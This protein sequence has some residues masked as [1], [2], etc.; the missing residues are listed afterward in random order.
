MSVSSSIAPMSR[1]EPG[2]GPPAAAKGASRLRGLSVSRRRA[3][4]SLRLHSR[5]L[6]KNTRFLLIA[7][8]IVVAL[9]SLGV[10]VSLRA[11]ESE[12]HEAERNA[13]FLGHMSHVADSIDQYIQYHHNAV[14]GLLRIAPRDPSGRP[15]ISQL[16]TQ[17][18]AV[19]GA[20]V[21]VIYLEQWSIISE[22]GASGIS[23]AALK[24]L[25]ARVARSGKVQIEAAGFGGYLVI[26]AP[27]EGEAAGMLLVAMLS[28]RLREEVVEHGR[29]S[30][31]A[32]ELR[33][34]NGEVLV[35]VASATGTTVALAYQARNT[36]LLRVG[37][38]LS[39]D[40]VA[41]AAALRLEH[42]AWELFAV[43]NIENGL[44]GRQLAAWV[45]LT[46]LMVLLLAPLTLIYWLI[47]VRFYKPIEE[48]K[49]WAFACGE[50]EL[51][52]RLGWSRRET[53]LA[54]LGRVMDQMAAKLDR[55][56]KAR[57]QFFAQVSH[58]IRTPMNAIIGFARLLLQGERVNET[59][60]E[61]LLMI[62]SSGESLLTIINDLLDFAK[63]EVGKL[64]LLP[65]PFRAAALLKSAVTMMESLARGKGLDLRLNLV[66]DLDAVIVADEAR[67]RQV[68][69]NL[70]GNAVKF[71]ERGFVEVRAT[72]TQNA[73]GGGWLTIIVSDTG[74]GLDKGVVD[75]LFSA[76]SQANIEIS[77]RF[78]GTGLG[79]SLCHQLSELMGGQLSVDSV[80]NVGTSF[81]FA[82]PVVYGLEEDLPNEVHET[83]V[84]WQS[85]NV[86]LAEDQFINQ[87]L[88]IAIL[89]RAGHRVTL[90]S[91]GVEAIAHARAAHFDVIL[92]DIQMPEMDGIEAARNIRALAGH[93]ATVPIIAVTAQA[94][95]DEIEK[96]LAAGM[97]KYVAK[98]IDERQLLVSIQRLTAGAAGADTDAQGAPSEA[99]GVESAVEAACRHLNMAVIEQVE[100]AI[101]RED[102]VMLWEK[103]AI[104]LDELLAEARTALE[105]GD[106][107]GLAAIAHKLVGSAGALGASAASDLCRAIERDAK[108]G[109]N[110]EMRARVAQLSQI[111]VESL[112]VINRRFDAQIRLAAVP[113]GAAVRAAE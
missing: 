71:T 67:L 32:I 6:F 18:E 94:L 107:T 89:E 64:A 36:A 100:V 11:V 38:V 29:S 113:G 30:P 24:S 99:D 26:A 93:N 17:L 58:E 61:Q 60:R 90:A 110:P 53:D 109:G 46:L 69:I 12:L 15:I 39:V 52:H 81:T 68:L 74:T 33:D 108:A 44:R 22:S 102:A 95:P 40:K 10:A 98:P 84:A 31:L 1:S 92:M 106:L 82:I 55:E 66:G 35:D 77:R 104:L 45:E 13:R 91:S 97:T 27:D 80:V 112:E 28:D 72:Q 7:G 3:A 111:A 54:D 34:P 50:G 105:S 65:V 101:G 63:A 21:H 76:Y 42:T 73:E 85:R 56:T 62:R 20:I 47:V 5:R 2:K 79:L 103:L 9:M 19:N 88:A 4:I 48:L 87:R 51:T 25:A 59:Q 41:I 83:A 75:R 37:R 43:D 16:A 70:I 86:L 57:S 8:A 96:C 49:A 23:R 14:V 78:G